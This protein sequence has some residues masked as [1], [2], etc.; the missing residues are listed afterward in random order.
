VDDVELRGMVQNMQLIIEQTGGVGLAAPQ[1]GSLRSILVY[2]MPGAEDFQ[3]LVNPELEPLDGEQTP[4]LE[5]CLSIPGI[6]LPVLRHNKVKV[7]ATN[8][9]GE[10]YQFEA[11][12]LEARILQHEVDHLNGILIIDRVSPDLKRQAMLAWND[13][14]ST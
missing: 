5:G 14:S 8:M 11:V 13:I 3:I 9:L 12:E 4:A 1:I 10:H 6:Q 2:R 7:K